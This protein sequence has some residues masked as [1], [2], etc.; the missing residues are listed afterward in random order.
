M[1]IKAREMGKE[2]FKI[3]GYRFAF[4]VQRPIFRSAD[5][6]F[7]VEITGPDIQKLKSVA[8]DLIGKLIR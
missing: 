8:L 4:A 7:Q 5:K 3:P 2:I 1:A 6:T